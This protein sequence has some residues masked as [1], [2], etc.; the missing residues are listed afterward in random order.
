MSPIPHASCPTT[1]VYA[2]VEVVWTLLTE[3]TAWG[4]FFDVRIIAVTPSGTATVGQIV[5]GESGPRFLRLKL[6]FQYVEIDVSRYRLL[7]D[8]RM[9]LGITVR[10]ELTCASIDTNRCRVNYGCNFEF[11]HGWRG[12][13]ARFLL[14]REIDVGTSDS[15]SRLKRMAEQIHARASIKTA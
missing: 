15:L 13:V 1:V 14:R 12:D 2:P 10:E 11:P 6:V 4:E 3:P 5:C 7:L 9:P 8:V